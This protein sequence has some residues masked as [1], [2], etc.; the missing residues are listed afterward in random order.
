MFPLAFFNFYNIFLSFLVFMLYYTPLQSTTAACS[1]DFD[2]HLFAPISPWNFFTGNSIVLAYG[3][4]NKA[5]W[6]C[7]IP[8]HCATLWSH[9]LH[10]VLNWWNWTM[11]W[12]L[13]WSGLPVPKNPVWNSALFQTSSEVRHIC[14]RCV[15]TPT[16]FECTLLGICPHRLPAQHERG[17]SA[18]IFLYFHIFILLVSAH[19]WGWMEWRKRGRKFIIFWQHGDLRARSRGWIR[20]SPPLRS[21]T[22]SH[23]CT[24]LPLSDQVCICV[25]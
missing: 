23:L 9:S 20:R 22:P 24:N 21:R 17:R 15:L 2:K 6:V 7:V 8:P 1:S 25:H 11:A 14:P 3:I 10:M 19:P 16:H 13:D 18:L 4:G 5:R 12:W